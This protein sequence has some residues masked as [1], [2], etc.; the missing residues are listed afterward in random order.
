MPVLDPPATIQSAVNAGLKQLASLTRRD[1][2]AQARVDRARADY[3]YFESYYLGHYFTHSAGEFHLELDAFLDEPGSCVVRLPRGHGKSVKITLGRILHAMLYR[4][5]QC[6]LLVSETFTKASAFLQFVQCELEQNERIRADF[7]DLRGPKW[8]GEELALSND[9]YLRAFGEGQKIRGTRYKQYRPDLIVVDDPESI[10]TVQSQAVRQKR[11]SWFKREVMGALTRD[12]KIVLIGTTVHH[13][14]LVRFVPKELGFRLKCF[15]AICEWP[16]HMDLWKQCE[17]LYHEAGADKGGEQIARAFY[18]KHKRQ[19]DAGAVVLWPSYWDLLHLMLRRFAMGSVAFESE[20]QDNAIDP[21]A[22][23]FKEEWIR[24]YT[25][26]EISDLA[27]SVFIACDP[28][29]GRRD[30]ADFS[31]ILVGGVVRPQT[32]F[33]LESIIDRMSPGDLIN[34]LFRLAQKWRP[35]KVGMETNQFQVLLADRLKEKTAEH[36][37]FLPVEEMQN[38]TDKVLRISSISPLVENGILR[39][40]KEDAKLIEQLVF[41]PKADHDD[42]PDALEMLVRLAR[43]GGPVEFKRAGGTRDG[44]GA[45]DFCGDRDLKGFE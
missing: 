19:M 35:L 9:V 5:A 7:G 42:G 38:Y 14:A 13:D 21:G 18:L 12:G 16:K 8:S 27:L 37:M 45:S 20:F 4:E 33:I 36:R 44:A 34:T 41:F 26:E 10:E 28:S 43:G 39:F 25:P 17:R 3:A 6:I 24:Y 32:L 15:E 22:Q 23:R 31:A 2:E 1:P 40:R 11:Q 30:Q 29:L